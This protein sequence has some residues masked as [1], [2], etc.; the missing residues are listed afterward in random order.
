[1]EFSNLRIDFGVR[2]SA[3][4]SVVREIS[5]VNINITMSIYCDMYNLLSNFVILVFNVNPKNPPSPHLVGKVFNMKFEIYE[6]ARHVGI[7][8]IM[9]YKNIFFI[10]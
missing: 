6:R 9:V 8:D 2:F 4:Y 3:K 1:M 10:G 5:T 7:V